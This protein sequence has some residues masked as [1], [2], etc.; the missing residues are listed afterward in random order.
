MTEYK[1]YRFIISGGGTGGHI[2]P[3]IA[4]A[5]EIKRRFPSS[6]FLFVGAQ[7]R[8]E[9][10]KVPEA[11]YHIVGLWISGFQRRVTIENLFFPFKVFFSYMAARRIVKNFKPDAAIGFGGYASGPVMIAATRKKVPSMIQEQNSY[12]GLTNKS[13]GKKVE[14][15]CVAYENMEKYFPK[16]KIRLT[17]NPVRK[18]I[19]YSGQKRDK[20]FAHFGLEKS[21]KTIFVMGGSLGARTINRTLEQG[22]SQLVQHGHQV[23]WQTGRF[24]YEEVLKKMREL[25]LEGIRVYQFIKE[26]DLAYAAADVVISRAGALSVS[27][28][29]L[30]GKPVIFVPSPNVAEDH[31]TK[32]AKAFEE[33][34]AAVV[35]KDNEAGD[36][37]INTT[38]DLIED[39]N[40]QQTLAANIKKLARPNATE[41]IVDELMELVN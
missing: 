27:E 15:V 12:A 24:Y 32:N 2:Y 6:Q 33:K 3:A 34:E 36:K 39:D 4:V 13:L 20:A 22:V 17:G 16:S 35:V 7:G 14:K 41:E 40:L 10:K 9:M 11:G 19:L 29:A 5:D 38:I 1:P 31:Q 23:I 8:M 37:L 21:R 18:D 25:N 30:V 26:M 28:L